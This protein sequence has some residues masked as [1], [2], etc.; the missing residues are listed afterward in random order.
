[1][2]SGS[3]CHRLESPRARSRT[4]T[5]Q[6]LAMRNVTLRWRHAPLGAAQSPPPAPAAAREE[7]STLPLSSPTA[8][9][10]Q[11]LHQIGAT[12]PQPNV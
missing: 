11:T 6:R 5:K 10:P 1:M 2:A 3:L 9:E 8:T 7:G 12:P 4:S